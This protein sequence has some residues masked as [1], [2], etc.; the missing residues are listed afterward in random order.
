MQAG[1]PNIVTVT[2]NT[3][4][5][6]SPDPLPARPGNQVRWRGAMAQ[7]D[8]SAGDPFQPSQA[9]LHSNGAASNPVKAHGAQARY[10]YSVTINGQIFDPVIV[11]DP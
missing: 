8:F 6:V 2:V 4:G 10:K 11:I 9:V 5:S 7:I 3:D 1:N